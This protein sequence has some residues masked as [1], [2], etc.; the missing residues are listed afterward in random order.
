[1][2][3]LSDDE[4]VRAAALGRVSLEELAT[5]LRDFEEHQF[6][7]L[8]AWLR[9]HREPDDFINASILIF[10][11]TEADLRAALEGPAPELGPDLPMLAERTVR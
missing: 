11:L 5:I 9:K 8:T 2:P 10:R 4:R 6:A 7:R 1:M 3:L